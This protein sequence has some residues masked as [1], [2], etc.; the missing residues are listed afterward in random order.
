MPL[1]E[2]LSEIS[3]TCVFCP[4]TADAVIYAPKAPSDEG[5]GFCEAKDWGR[6]F[7][8]LVS[9]PPSSPNGE[10]TSLIRGRLVAAA[11]L[12]IAKAFWNHRRCRWFSGYKKI[13]RG[14]PLPIFIGQ[15]WR[16]YFRCEALCRKAD[17]RSANSAAHYRPLPSGA[18][19]APKW[20]APYQGIWGT[21]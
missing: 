15:W 7:A 3:F 16:Y 8:L 18:S 9:L 20:A 10:S 4:A 12:G 11:E 6:E 14:D 17:S 5:A 1:A 21:A 13:G 19:H 2:H